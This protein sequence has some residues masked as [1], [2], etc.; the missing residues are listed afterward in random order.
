MSA[1]IA[2]PIWQSRYD[3]QLPNGKVQICPIAF[4]ARPF[5]TAQFCIPEVPNRYY[6]VLF[7]YWVFNHFPRFCSCKPFQNTDGGVK[8]WFSWKILTRESPQYR[9][10]VLFLWGRTTFGRDSGL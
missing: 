7:R 4:L 10:C 5:R 9:R 6:L 2:F 1:P 8:F 3:F